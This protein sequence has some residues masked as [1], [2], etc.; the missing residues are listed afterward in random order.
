MG[1]A[2]TGTLR[3][4]RME[5]APLQYIVK[6][7]KEK[8]GSSDE[9]TDV[10][11]NITAVRWK[12]NELVNAISTFTGKQPIQQVKNGEWILDNQTSQTNMICPWGELIARIKIYWRIW[13]TQRTPTKKWWWPLF[14]FALDVAVNNAYQIY[15]QP[16]LYPGEYRLDALDFCRPSVDANYCL[17]KESTAV[18][19]TIHR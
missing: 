11:S 19:N 16:H 15:C 1:V 12:G 10:S 17:Y 7:N 3:A 2:A 8:H 9:V 13:L 6:L 5:N 4:N 18:Y 14:Q